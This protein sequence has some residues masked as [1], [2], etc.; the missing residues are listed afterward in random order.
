MVVDL[1]G[2]FVIGGEYMRNA[3]KKKNKLVRV[4][5]TSIVQGM[6]WKKEDGD[7]K[8]KKINEWNCTREQGQQETER[9]C[10]NE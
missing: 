8:E 3:K 4:L 7:N 1:Y 9:T 6:Y 10:M 5:K 2:H